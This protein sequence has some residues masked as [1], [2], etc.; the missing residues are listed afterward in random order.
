[1]YAQIESQ[2]RDPPTETPQCFL[3]LSEI[4]KLLVYQREKM[5]GGGG[6]AALF[7]QGQ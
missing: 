1:M 5:G 2:H 7:P 4:Q 6:K 3:S